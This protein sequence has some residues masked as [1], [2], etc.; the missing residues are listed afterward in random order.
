[1]RDVGLNLAPTFVT[2]TPWTTW[3]GYRNLLQML[4]DLD[5][6]EN[7]APIQLAMR[8]LIPAGSRLLELGDIREIIRPF[9]RRALCYPWHHS[10][11]TLDHLCSEIQKLIRREKRRK[12]TRTE[13]FG[14]ILE[15]TQENPGDFHLASRATIPYLN[16]P[17][18]C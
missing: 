5:L 12:A 18:Y 4:M 1:M 10:D 13:L 7:V 9:D 17:W 16:E 11:E 8:L 14:R 3:R 2:F 15:L 6:T